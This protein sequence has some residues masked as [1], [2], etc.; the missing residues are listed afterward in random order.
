MIATFA[1]PQ[2]SSPS[3]ARRATTAAQ[4][5]RRDSAEAVGSFLAKAARVAAERW[6]NAPA[7]NFADIARTHGGA[8]N[9][10]IGQY[11]SITY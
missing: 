7:S 5:A 8:E 11:A 3:P 10:I 6:Q 4:T 1:K 9:Y 2:H